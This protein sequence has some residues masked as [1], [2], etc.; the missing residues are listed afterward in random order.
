MPKRI[1]FTKFGANSA[2]GGFAPGDL[3]TCPDDLAEHLVNEV[4]VAEYVVPATQSA[5][6]E[7]VEAEGDGQD[8]PEAAEAPAAV[9]RVSRKRNAG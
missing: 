8:A 5:P 1:K 3:F 9:Q 4:G 7:P 6:V 2:F